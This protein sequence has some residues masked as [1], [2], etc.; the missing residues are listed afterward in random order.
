MFEL[1][2][3]KTPLRKPTP[4]LCALL[5]TPQKNTLCSFHFAC[6]PVGMVRALR[7]LHPNAELVVVGSKGYQKLAFVEG[8][9]VQAVLM[10]IQGE[11]SDIDLTETEAEKTEARKEKP[12]EKKPSVKPKESAVLKEGEISQDARA[13]FDEFGKKPKGEVVENALGLIRSGITLPK[14]IADVIDIEEGKDISFT[15]KSL[16]HL[17]EK[18]KE[19]ERLFNAIPSILNKPVE[20]RKSKQT[21]D[22]GEDRF[23]VVSSE[24]VKKHRS[25]AVLIEIQKIGNDIIVSVMS[26]KKSYLN[27]FEL[28]W[29]ATTPPSNTAEAGAGGLPSRPAT[30]KRQDKPIIAKKGKEVKPLVSPK[31]PQQAVSR[32]KK[33]LMRRGVAKG[34][35]ECARYV[36]GTP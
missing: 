7:T 33:L 17:S 18:G 35:S 32:A 23:F 1:S 29:R 22:Q 25:D 6:L 30:Q 20:I 9:E 3:S 24:K 26:T 10:R 31:L 8:G 11:I 16:K 12:K 21:G 36:E 34:T 15:R 13:L 19:G 4:P 5:A 28:L 14:E 2:L 27:G